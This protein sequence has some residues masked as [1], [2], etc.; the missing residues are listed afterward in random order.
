MKFT[1]RV[2]KTRKLTGL[3]GG[4]HGCF[5]CTG[6]QRSNQ[7][8]SREIYKSGK[9]LKNWSTEKVAGDGMVGV[10]SSWLRGLGANGASS[11]AARAPAE[12]RNGLRSANQEREL[13][14]NAYGSGEKIPEDAA[15][16][17]AAG[18]RIPGRPDGGPRTA[19]KLSTSAPA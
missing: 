7:I 14:S 19:A 12:G 18:E 4:G 16:G 5:C 15:G 2:K 1:A 17:S 11:P 3:L 8:S 9:L 10:A 6:R 13:G